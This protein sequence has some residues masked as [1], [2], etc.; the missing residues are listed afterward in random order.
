MESIYLP[1]EIYGLI[2]ENI[3]TRVTLRNL[4]LVSKEFN[5]LM[6]SKINYEKEQYLR[7]KLIQMEIDKI[8]DKI[9]NCN[10]ISVK[11]KTSDLYSYFQ[12][13]K[14]YR[15]NSR[16]SRLRIVLSDNYFKIISVKFISEVYTMK[17]NFTMS[18]LETLLYQL[19]DRNLV[20]K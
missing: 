5:Y 16:E 17:K 11:L 3:N 19:I 15:K 6:K 9:L 7:K 13:C 4:S 8:I 14:I 2:I 10:S 12:D 18:N 1:L 20:V